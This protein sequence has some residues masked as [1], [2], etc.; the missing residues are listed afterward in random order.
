MPKTFDI[1]KKR[2]MEVAFLVFIIQFL[3]ILSRV[4]NYVLRSGGTNYD[5]LMPLNW[6]LSIFRFVVYVFYVFFYAGFLRSACV[7]GEQR[8]RLGTLYKIGSPFFG[9]ILIFQ[10]IAG[11]IKMGLLIYATSYSVNLLGKE[12][13]F[14][15][16]WILGLVSL[17]ITIAFL[18][19]RFFIPSLIIVRKLNINTAFKALKHYKLFAAKEMLIIFAFSYAVRWGGYPI[20]R[21]TSVIPPVYFVCQI[22][23]GIILHVFSL[24]IM[25]S[26][27]KFIYDNTETASEVTGEEVE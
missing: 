4:I 20:I 12:T 2:W 16:R 11:L 7:D 19:L 9:Q 10:L 22:V 21:L 27:V 23:L 1:L 15:Y 14:S 3:S 24:A 25:L 6:T 5:F 13:Y 17:A 18:K 26:A 8:Q